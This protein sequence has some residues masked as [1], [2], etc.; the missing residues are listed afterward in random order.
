MRLS[1]FTPAGH[2]LKDA[3]EGRFHRR[4]CS[5]GTRGEELSLCYWT[6]KCKYTLNYIQWSVWRQSNCISQGLTSCPTEP[7]IH[8]PSFS[9]PPPP[10]FYIMSLET[11]LNFPSYSK[12]VQPEKGKSKSILRE[13]SNSSEACSRDY[14][15]TKQTQMRKK[16]KPSTIKF[17]YS[18]FSAGAAAVNRHTHDNT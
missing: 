5:N 4:L 12:F 6:Q 1:I 17:P 16:I 9:L 2:E 11:W 14:L 15:T 10:I 18:K 3:R 13:T 7:T 8:P